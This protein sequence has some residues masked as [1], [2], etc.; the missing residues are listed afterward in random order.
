MKPMDTTEASQDLYLS[1]IGV[2]VDCC[3]GADCA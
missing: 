3:T 1:Y 2:P